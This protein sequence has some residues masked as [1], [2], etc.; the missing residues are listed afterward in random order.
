[1]RHIHWPRAIA[2][3]VAAYVVAVG[4]ITLLFGNPLIEQILF[5]DGAGQSPKV[6]AVWLELAPLPA[7]TPLWRDFGEISGRGLVVQGLL[8]LWAS[9]AVIVYASVW[10]ATSGS[11]WRKGVTFG[12]AVWALLF[13]FFEALVPFNILGEPFR[14]VLLELALQLVAM[15]AMGMVVAVVYRPQRRRMIATART[16]TDG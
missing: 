15:L 16:S 11:V 10:N 5:T 2:A 9:A 7:V 6:L 3:A 4:S 12:L 13:L 14:L 1:M 8:L